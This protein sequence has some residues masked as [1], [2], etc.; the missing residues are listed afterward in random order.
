MS[1]EDLKKQIGEP[2]TEKTP[3][4]IKELTDKVKENWT[5]K[6]SKEKSDTDLETPGPAPKAKEKP[7]AELLNNPIVK[8]C[9]EIYKNGRTNDVEWR[10]HL[11]E[12]VDGVYTNNPDQNEGVLKTI[13]FVL[14]IATS[15]LSRFRKFYKSFKLEL[16]KEKIELGYSWSHFKILNDIK[17]GLVKERVMNQIDEKGEAPK[18]TELQDTINKE[19]E[20]QLD[21]AA[22]SSAAD[23]E[24]NNSTPSPSRPIN[25]ALKHAEKLGDC[26]ADIFLQIKGGVDFASD[27]QEEKYNESMDE[28]KTRLREIIEVSNSIIDGSITEPKDGGED[29]DGSEKEEKAEGKG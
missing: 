11:G 15:D 20:Q 23:G 12:K 14:D 1:I 28:L 3:E 8:E 6:D 7:T 18:T 19:K 27:K 5:P 22:T 29:E 21:R 4:Q 13:S 24:K 26:L 25:G 9:H 16:I 17:D 2:S 10:W